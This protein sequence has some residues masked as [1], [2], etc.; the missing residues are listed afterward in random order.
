M[1]GPVVPVS[2]ARGV[3]AI[4]TAIKTDI[5]DAV[6]EG[7][8]LRVQMVGAG[9]PEDVVNP[10]DGSSPAPD[11]GGLEVGS[12]V[13]GIGGGVSGV[14]GDLSVGATCYDGDGRGGAT[15]TCPERGGGFSVA[16]ET[17]FG[18]SGAL[19]VVAGPEAGS[20]MAHVVAGY[21][22]GVAP[23]GRYEG[24][25]IPS[26]LGPIILGFVWESGELRWD[27][28]GGASAS[29]DE[30]IGAVAL[31]GTYGVGP[32]VT[33]TYT[34]TVTGS[35]GSTATASVT[36]MPDGLVLVDSVGNIFLMAESAGTWTAAYMGLVSELPTP[37][38]P[39]WPSGTVGYIERIPEYETEP[40]RYP[41]NWRGVIGGGQ[42]P[43][44][45][46]DAWNIAPVADYANA[47]PTGAIAD[48]PKTSTAAVWDTDLAV[49][50]H[51][52]LLYLVYR[53]FGMEGYQGNPGN[54]TVLATLDASNWYYGNVDILELPVSRLCAVSW[55]DNDPYCGVVDVLTT[56][57]TTA[58]LRLLEA[59]VGDNWA[60]EQT[61]TVPDVGVGGTARVEPTWWRGGRLA[62]GS[63][64]YL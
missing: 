7:R 12:V 61:V 57:S 16:P 52:G 64:T 41:D 50:P 2:P 49:E 10:L 22:S 55:G 13:T 8:E 28:L 46:G 21:E 24:G 38:P 27:T 60:I 35:D 37:H 26:M 18:A 5:K 25:E 47:S 11:G 62:G 33:T 1:I 54:I 31:S 9:C 6:E 53:E 15:A 51:T 44:T 30:G 19:A 40:E 43:Y 36:V 23:G 32:A 4:V 39:P 29:I 48:L 63:L 59:G 3:G 20:V 34:L 58:A 14:S 42:V 56:G 17:S 45:L